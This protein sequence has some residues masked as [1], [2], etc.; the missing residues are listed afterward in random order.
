A[1]ALALSASPAAGAA[2]ILAAAPDLAR[3]VA[4][5]TLSWDALPDADEEAA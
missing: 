2:A 4:E 1:A 3:A 5:G